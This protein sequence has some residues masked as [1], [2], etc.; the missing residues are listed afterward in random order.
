MKSEER[1]NNVIENGYQMSI[2]DYISK[3][4]KILTNNFG[5]YLAFTFLFIAVSF[6]AGSIPI[7][8]NIFSY[9]VSPA[10][11]IGFITFTYATQTSPYFSFN[12]FF[13]GF[14]KILPLAIINIFVTFIV[15]L[16]LSPLLKVI[17]L[18][19]KDLFLE[20]DRSNPDDMIALFNEVSDALIN[21][22]G[23]VIVSFL[24]MFI[25]YIL[26]RWSSYFVY[27]YDAPPLK[28]IKYSAQLVSKNIVGQIGLTVT[29]LLFIFG[30]V[31]VFFVG[32]VVTFPLM[33]LIDYVAFCT[34]TDLLDTSQSE[35]DIVEPL[36]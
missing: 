36:I 35:Q 31:M 19:Y 17:I 8:N 16:T 3:A 2:S 9:I 10:L 6:V 15:I 21:N 14:K 25:V 11:T 26:V 13:D 27:F 24:L 4:W 7:V 29:M 20:I 5:N 30:G 12:N 34:I 28:A 22:I 32:V 23:L 18:P 33:I 1:I